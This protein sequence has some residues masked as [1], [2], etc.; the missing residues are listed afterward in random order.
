MVPSKPSHALLLVTLLLPAICTTA[1]AQQKAP[2]PAKTFDD[3]SY[4]GHPSRVIDFRKADDD[5]PDDPKA[6]RGWSIHH[7]NFGTTLED[8][9]RQ[10]GL[11]GFLNYPRADLPFKNE[12]EFLVHHLK[13]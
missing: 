2:V 12:V 10:E 11:D 4:G 3:V 5:I 6:A 8:R 9:L 1:Q 13:K 7:A